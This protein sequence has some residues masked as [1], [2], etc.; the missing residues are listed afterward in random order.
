MLIRSLFIG[1]LCSLA[2]ADDFYELLGV[3]KTASQKEIRKG[4]KEKALKHHPDKNTV[5][6]W[7]FS[8]TI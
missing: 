4:F 7:Y 8:F 2:L 6:V 3:T 5:S 1:L